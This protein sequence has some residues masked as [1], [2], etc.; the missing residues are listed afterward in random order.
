M[1]TVQLYTLSVYSTLTYETARCSTD[2]EAGEGGHASRMRE[3]PSS[4]RHAFLHCTAKPG[5]E[6]P[7][8][9]NTSHSLGTILFK[10]RTVE[11]MG[12]ITDNIENFYKVI[13]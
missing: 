9:R 13:V 10:A 5:D 3:S 8:Y 6:I 4:F 1:S 2:P 7:A 12:S 11:E